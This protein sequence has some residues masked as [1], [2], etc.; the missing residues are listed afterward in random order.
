MLRL[1]LP[2]GFDFGGIV[3]RRTLALTASFSPC[4]GASSLSQ[5]HNMLVI[6]TVPPIR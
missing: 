1:D 2:N 4:D 6:E 3:G 5:W